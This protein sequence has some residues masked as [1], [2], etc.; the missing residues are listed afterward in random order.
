MEKWKVEEY[1]CQESQ[2]AKE[3][4]HIFLYIPK[5]FR[6]PRPRAKLTLLDE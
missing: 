5:L 1:A 3:S 2:N 6:K 4:F